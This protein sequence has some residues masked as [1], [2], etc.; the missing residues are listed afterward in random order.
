MLAVEARA[1]CHVPSVGLGQPSVV[2]GRLLCHHRVC[3]VALCH[4]FWD[5]LISSVVHCLQ[6]IE[7]E[8]RA[9]AIAEKES[10]MYEAMWYV[11]HTSPRRW[12]GTGR[13]LFLPATD[14]TAED[15]VSATWL[16]DTLL[17]DTL[18]DDAMAQV[19]R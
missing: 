19:R 9:M 16:D 14:D 5:Q 13:S 18:L 6:V 8:L 10:R 11:G 15:P 12:S 7:P 2:L 4:S 17:D 3:V 1:A